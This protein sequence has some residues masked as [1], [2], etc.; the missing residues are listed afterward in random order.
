M[1]VFWYGTHMLWYDEL[2]SPNVVKWQ[3]SVLVLYSKN[4]FGKY[5][6]FFFIEGKHTKI[7]IY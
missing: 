1:I 3:V 5:K 4:V 7:Y 6:L 2:S